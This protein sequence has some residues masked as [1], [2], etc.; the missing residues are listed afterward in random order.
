[1]NNK[2]QT[3]LK[4]QEL[5]DDDL[6]SFT[7]ETCGDP[8]IVCSLMETD[9]GM[10]L[11]YKSYYCESQQTAC[12]TS[13]GNYYCSKRCS[14]KASVSRIDRGDLAPLEFDGEGGVSLEP[15]KFCTGDRTE[16][17]G[18]CLVILHENG[19]KIVEK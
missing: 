11:P 16:C 13:K 12:L 4:Q 2:E 1:M 15:S 18:K 6:P 7:C 3:K 8:V 17:N 5:W 9:K 14:L 19:K 10:Y